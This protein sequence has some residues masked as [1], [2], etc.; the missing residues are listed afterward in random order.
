MDGHARLQRV[1]Q[2]EG[3]RVMESTDI[4][5]YLEEVDSIVKAAVAVGSASVEVERPMT[6]EEL[7]LAQEV[8]RLQRYI[9]ELE[10]EL[11]DLRGI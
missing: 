9:E 2:P 5:P 6:A 7:L 10:G 3:W 8:R 1:E 4:T 11:Y